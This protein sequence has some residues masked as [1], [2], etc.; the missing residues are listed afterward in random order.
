MWTTPYYLRCIRVKQV[1]NTEGS[2]KD[3]IEPAFFNLDK[4]IVFVE[5][6]ADIKGLYLQYC[7][8]L[9]KAI[10]YDISTLKG[11]TVDVV[12]YSVNKVGDKSKAFDVIS[13]G[14]KG[15][16]CG[17]WMR[18]DKTGRLL[19]LTGESF[20]EITEKSWQ[21]WLVEKGIKVND[22]DI[23]NKFKNIIANQLFMN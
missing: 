6:A 13:I 15:E 3:I 12:G 19:S 2:F 10:G 21:Q 9:S 22:K 18:D 16:L 8:E 7:N 14:L 5:K 4:S 20:T 11:K 17:V 23:D 1:A